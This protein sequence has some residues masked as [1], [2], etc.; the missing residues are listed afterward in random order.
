M[1]AAFR[2]AI[3]YQN[4]AHKSPR[5]ALKASAVDGIR[6]PNIPGKRNFEERNQDRHFMQ[7][8]D[9]YITSRELSVPR[10][11][12][13]RTTPM[14][15]MGTARRNVDY[16]RNLVI[17]RRVEGIY[18]FSGRP[19]IPAID[20]NP[21][22]LKIDGFSRRL[23]FGMSQRSSHKLS[24]FKAKE[25]P[26]DEPKFQIS[27]PFSNLIRSKSSMRLE[28]SSETTE[29]MK[30]SNLKSALKLSKSD[31]KLNCKLE[32]KWDS[33]SDTRSNPVSDWVSDTSSK[34]ETELP[35]LEFKSSNPHRRL[36][37][38]SSSSRSFIRSGVFK[39]RRAAASSVRLTS[40]DGRGSLRANK[41]HLIP[42]VRL[43]T[44][45]STGYQTQVSIR[46]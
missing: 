46:D 20:Y 30:S 33:D 28:M 11:H 36:S 44:G 23:S 25:I 26:V 45:S 38:K 42:R 31:P 32:V 19:E 22:T 18:D 8:S 16:R 39:V 12:F 3:D 29:S 5:A 6:R 34:S 41:Q 40:K 15:P 13:K 14:N 7:R 1:P 43:K 4:R 9:A 35:S 27:T 24:V 37:I 10:V 2:E 21:P 17:E